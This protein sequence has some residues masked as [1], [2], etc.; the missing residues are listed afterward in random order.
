M[1]VPDRGQAQVLAFPGACPGGPRAVMSSLGKFDPV[2]SNS[3]S[4]RKRRNRM[5]DTGWLIVAIVAGVLAVVGWIVRE[6]WIIR[7]RERR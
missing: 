5:G 6:R 1:G 2:K 3:G 7:R 4:K